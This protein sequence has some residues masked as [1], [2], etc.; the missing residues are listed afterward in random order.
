MN[1]YYAQIDIMKGSRHIRIKS[2]NTT[3]ITYQGF[4]QWEGGMGGLPPHP[5]IF[6]KPPSIKTNATLMGCLPFKNEVPPTEKQTPPL[7]NEHPFQDTF[8][9]KKIQKTGNC[10]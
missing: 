7:K 6:S 3:A 9:R 2:D 5:T 1:R 4:P 10:H 8:P